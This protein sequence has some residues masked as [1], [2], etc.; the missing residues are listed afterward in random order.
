M[1]MEH[2][3]EHVAKAV[4]QDPIAIKQ[5]NLYKDGEMDIS[6]EI[7]TNLK[8]REMSQGMSAMFISQ[9]YDV[10]YLHSGRGNNSGYI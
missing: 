6:Y 4:D 3:L 9:C 5:K 7:L 2:V 1:F 8:I 10:T